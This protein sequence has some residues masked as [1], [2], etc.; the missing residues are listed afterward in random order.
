M[1][2][3][4]KI[5]ISVII[6]HYNDKTR[7]GLCLASLERQTLPRAMFEVIVADNGTPGG[8]DELEH[9]FSDVQFI[10]A[11]ERGAAHARNSAMARASGEI[12]AFIDADC[13]A[14]PDWL[15]RGVA[16]LADADF[17][18][19]RI[20]ISVERE[21]AP[22]PVEAFELVFGFRQRLYVE[23]KRFSATANLFVWRDVATQIGPFRNGVSEDLDWGRRAD[24]LGFRLAFNANS[25]VT[26]P[27][28]SDWSA[29]VQ[30][31]DRLTR[32]RW[33]GVEKRGL[34]SALRWTGLA[35]ATALSAA[36][37]LWA[38][39][40]SRELTRLRDRLAAAGVL[41]RIRFWRARK[42]IA[43]LATA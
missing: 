23:R 31:W 13:I 21:N 11:A 28:R 20:D 19:G 39:F 29:L 3:E 24:A 37:H 27:A 9:K 30:K 1:A 32:E 26:H 15:E 22:S 17:V 43:L 12:F 10:T 41:A 33:G 5:R 40:T 8:V 34:K 7:L 25:I 35:V 4:H 2:D 38:V 42:M 14:D 16:A 18:G 36:P 6:P